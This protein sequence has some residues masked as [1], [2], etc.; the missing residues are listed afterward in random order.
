VCFLSK[1][2][3]PRPIIEFLVTNFKYFENAWNQLSNDNWRV[4]LYERLI[5]TTEQASQRIRA[6][7]RFSD[8]F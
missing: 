7:L 3:Q 8:D 2:N 6:I 4:G 1:S 5:D